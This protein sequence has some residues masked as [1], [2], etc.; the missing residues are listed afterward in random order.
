MSLSTTNLL[1]T[2]TKNGGLLASA[3]KCKQYYRENFKVV[4]PVEYAFEDK[5][6]RNLNVPILES[7]QN[8]L[9][10][11]DLLDT[12]VESHT[13]QQL[14]RD[15]HQYR[16]IQDGQYFKANC[17]FSEEL[18][19]SVCLYVDDFEMCNPLGTSRRKYKL[20]AIYWILSNI[21]STFQSTLSSIYLALLCKTEDVKIYG[22]EKVLQPLLHHLKT[23]EQHGVYVHQLRTFR[24]GT[25][26]CVMADNFAAHCRK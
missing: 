24:K 14:R 25:V 8:L 7:L 17:F 5:G 2:A 13:S 23:L 15:A 16:S 21:P 26:Q 12:V 3:F 10:Q 6:N 9:C 19:I 18:R 22:F 4:D 20:C 1:L 11:N